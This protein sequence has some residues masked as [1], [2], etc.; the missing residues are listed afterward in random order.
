MPEVEIYQQLIDSLQQRGGYT[1]ATWEAPG[2]NGYQDTFYVFPYDWRMDNVETAQLLIRRIEA[3]KRKLGK[4]DLKFNVI[5]HSMGGLITRY[6]AMYGDRGLS[7][8]TPKPNWAGTK[9]F[10][11]I[12]LLG[13][14]NE[15]SILA[16]EAFING[17]SYAPVNLPFVRDINI[18][19]VFT[20]PAL[21]QLLPHEGSLRAYNEDMEPIN[22]DV[23]DPATWEEYEWAIWKRRGFEKQFDKSEQRVARLYFRHVLE[24]AKQFQIALN[25]RPLDTARSRS[26]WSDQTV[27]Q[28]TTG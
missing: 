28:P 12:F 3:L 18:Y 5:A 22:I 17:Y 13:T 16:L 21:Y 10:D 9:H 14:P 11:K 2:E 6:A 1:E 4:P 15:G 7:A 20:I 19:D 26:F 24:R 23:F 8:G 25:A 27:S